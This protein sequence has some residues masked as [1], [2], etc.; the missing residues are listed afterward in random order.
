M[1][2]PQRAASLGWGTIHTLKNVL[3]MAHTG[4]LWPL[5]ITGS[6]TK[7][8]ADF[9]QASGSLLQQEKGSFALA[10]SA[11]PLPRGQG[12]HTGPAS[13]KA[14]LAETHSQKESEST[15]LSA[16]YLS[17]DGDWA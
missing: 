5:H 17:Q 16:V 9:P 8:D 6:I 1:L 14:L 13:S 10:A 15:R 2:G 11:S 3:K 12:S 7:G 4:G